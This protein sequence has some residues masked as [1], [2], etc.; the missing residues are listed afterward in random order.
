MIPLSIFL[1]TGQGFANFA[2]V[3][4][5]SDGTVSVIDTD[6]NIVVTTIVVGN[7]PQAV[8][9]SPN[10]NYA[11]VTN[12]NDNSVSVIDTQT[13]NVINTI[14]DSSFNNPLGI[15]FTPNGTRAYVANN[16]TTTTSVIS[17]IATFFRT[18][19]IQIS[20]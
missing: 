19:R 12:Y 6:T 7:S 17:D 20:C 15:A 4:N 1:L 16:G 10:G 14:T 13:Y 3:T 18:L 9:I 8:A 2:Y 5:T 11:Y